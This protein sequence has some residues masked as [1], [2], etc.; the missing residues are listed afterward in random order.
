M[1]GFQGVLFL[2]ALVLA[3]RDSIFRVFVGI[4]GSSLDLSLSCRWYQSL[5]AW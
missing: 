2:L 5:S 1:L 3:L 4:Q